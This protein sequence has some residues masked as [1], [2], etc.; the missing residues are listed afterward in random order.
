MKFIVSGDRRVRRAI[1]PPMVWLS[2]EAARPV[3]L[4]LGGFSYDPYL[5]FSHSS[6]NIP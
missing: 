2:G 1:T 5:M 6:R 4:V 3:E